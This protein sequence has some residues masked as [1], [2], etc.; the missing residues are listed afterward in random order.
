L[1]AGRL[2]LSDILYIERNNF[3]LRGMGSGKEGT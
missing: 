1:L 3:V 2:I